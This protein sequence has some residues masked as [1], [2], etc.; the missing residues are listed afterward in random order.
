MKTFIFSTC[1]IICSLSQIVLAGITNIFPSYLVKNTGDN[2]TLS[3]TYPSVDFTRSDELRSVYLYEQN[4]GIEIHSSRVTIINSTTIDIE[5]TLPFY[6]PTAHNQMWEMRIET[7]SQGLATYLLDMQVNPGSHLPYPSSVKNVNSTN[8]NRLSSS[9]STQK[10]QLYFPNLDVNTQ[11]NWKIYFGSSPDDIVPMSAAKVISTNIIEVSTDQFWTAR[12]PLVSIYFESDES[13]IQVFPSAFQVIDDPSPQVKSFSTALSAYHQYGYMETDTMTVR[14]ENVDFT[15]D[16]VKS[17]SLNNG[18]SSINGRQINNIDAETFKFVFTTKNISNSGLYKLAIATEAIEDVFLNTIYLGSAPQVSNVTNKMG[19]YPNSILTGEQT[20]LGLNIEGVNLQ[21]LD[22]SQFNIYLTDIHGNQVYSEGAVKVISADSMEFDFN[23]VFGNQLGFNTLTIE[24]VSIPSMIKEEAISVQDMSSAY[25]YESMYDIDSREFTVRFSQIIETSSSFFGSGK[26]LSVRFGTLPNLLTKE[27]SLDWIQGLPRGQDFT[28][29]LTQAEE[30]NLLGAWKV[31]GSSGRIAHEAGLTE[32][33]LTGDPVR[34][35]NFNEWKNFNVYTSAS[36][37][38]FT[39]GY[40]HAPSFDFNNDTLSFGFETIGPVMLNSNSAGECAIVTSNKFGVNDTIP[41]NITSTNTRIENEQVFVSLASISDSFFSKLNRSAYSQPQILIKSDVFINEDSSSNIGLYYGSGNNDL[42]ILNGPIQNPTVYLDL[43]SQRI[44]L[45]FNSKVDTLYSKGKTIQLMFNQMNTTID[46][47]KLVIEDGAGW[48][49]G[50]NSSMSLNGTIGTNLFDEIN[51]KFKHGTQ[52]TMVFA[53][54]VFRSASNSSDSLAEVTS[55]DFDQV[56]VHST[57]PTLIHASFE[58]GNSDL[59]LR[60]SNEISSL[61][62][63]LNKPITLTAYKSNTEFKTIGLLQSQLGA[64][65]DYTEVRFELIQHV[66]D[67]INA[68]NS[69]GY[70][71]WTIEFEGDYFQ[72]AYNGNYSEGLLKSDQFNINSADGVVDINPFMIEN[73]AYNLVKNEIFI[74][75]NRRLDKDFAPSA[76]SQIKIRNF[77]TEKEI[78]LQIGNNI[79][80]STTNNQAAYFTLDDKVAENFEEMYGLLGNTDVRFNSSILQSA[81]GIS[82]TINPNTPFLLWFDKNFEESPMVQRVQY[83][84]DTQKLHIFLKDDINMN[85]SPFFT[86][87]LLAAGSIQLSVSKTF[88]D[89]MNVLTNPNLLFLNSMTDMSVSDKNRELIFDLSPYQAKLASWESQWSDLFIHFNEGIFTFNGGPSGSNYNNSK[90][91]ANVTVLSNDRLSKVV[92]TS[93]DESELTLTINHTG[94]LAPDFSSDQIYFVRQNTNDDFDMIELK[95]IESSNSSSN[96]GFLDIQQLVFGLNSPPDFDP[97]STTG[98]IKI[99]VSPSA[100]VN[101]NELG[102]SMAVLNDLISPSEDSQNN[103]LP[104]FTINFKTEMTNE[105][106]P[107]DV[108]FSLTNDFTD[109]IVGSNARIKLIPGRNL[110]FKYKDVPGNS[111]ELLVPLRPSVVHDYLSE[112]GV[113]VLKLQSEFEWNVDNGAAWNVGDDS[114]V[115]LFAGGP[116]YKMRAPATGSEFL[117][118]SLEIKVPDLY[119]TWS[120]RLQSYG[121]ATQMNWVSN[122]NENQISNVTYKSILRGNGYVDSVH[123]TDTKLQR[124]PLPIGSYSW[125]YEL[126][127]LEGIVLK[128]D[129]IEFEI[130]NTIEYTIDF[131][132]DDH[133]NWYMVGHSNTETP[134]L[135]NYP[136]NSS[137]FR[138]Y[139]DAEFDAL[140]GKNFELLNGESYK[141]GEGFWLYGLGLSKMSFQSLDDSIQSIVVES[142]FGEEGW[143]QITNP[144]SYPIPTEAVSSGGQALSVWKWNPRISDYEEE[145]DNLLPGVG[146]F[147]QVSSAEDVDIL[148]QPWFSSTERS[149]DQQVN[150]FSLLKTNSAFEGW[151]L[152]LNLVAGDKIDAN[153]FLG[154]SSQGAKKQ[155]ELPAGMGNR[156]SL[157]LDE[158]L[159]QNFKEMGSSEYKWTLNYSSNISGLTSGIIEVHGLDEVKANGYE[160]Y[161]NPQGSWKRLEKQNFIKLSRNS[162]VSEVIISKSKLNLLDLNR[163]SI[164]L[165]TWPKLVENFVNLDLVLPENSDKLSIDILDSQGDILYSEQSYI[166]STHIKRVLNLTEGV[167][168]TEPG[169]YFL[170]VKSA[171]HVVRDKFTFIPR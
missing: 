40:D 11:T 21:K 97:S 7:A 81:M 19:D 88:S 66:V 43:V 64:R 23:G 108:V 53:D 33:Y 159:S 138:W 113:Q 65:V 162:Q 112:T 34:K 31:N 98:P 68:F 133:S 143:V 151:S 74:T 54:N 140:Y 50:G 142:H 111:F 35:L 13:P 73:V 63:A 47:I 170:Q 51:A 131:E 152:S 141:T 16:G 160:V 102:W 17:V 99:Y 92:S 118:K 32:S 48:Q 79:R 156:V 104:F 76:S 70:S 155:Y 42:N 55:S 120:P 83:I 91:Y 77:Q 36:R 41:F 57:T 1:L 69:Q 59:N 27:I 115:L 8:P 169:I 18:N 37:G 126:Y 150:T 58:S 103:S 96:S 164:S 107:T 93:Y 24:H 134:D 95:D 124:W 87:Q 149:I 106:I 44:E 89:N 22:A 78:D 72:S 10:I 49:N 121:T 28:K 128:K 80:Y 105:V 9:T 90:S 3:L 38:P 82:L 109:S 61:N 26:T 123:S 117:S 5:V 84:H 130:S 30:T 171:N 100:F 119:P 56:Q 146:Y 86:N 101:N 114:N 25:I 129:T 168:L 85:L 158:G 137:A 166:Y 4:S 148:A 147:T 6:T 14:M 46:T 132:N 154:A 167:G 15:T 125:S 153:N 12:P 110:F 127:D 136:I 71:Q 52:V 157:S 145:L 165:Y 116:L 75:T 39:L 62:L 20:T 45:D 139:D 60:F 122:L 67:S 94:E 161:W 29:E 163:N 144:W 2:F 135:N